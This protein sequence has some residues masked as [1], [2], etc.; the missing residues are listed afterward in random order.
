MLKNCSV[1]VAETTPCTCSS[2][3]SCETLNR[4]TRILGLIKLSKY[5][6]IRQI[7]VTSSYSIPYCSNSEYW[8]QKRTQSES[9]Y[10]IILDVHVSKAEHRIY[11]NDICYK[12]CSESKSTTNTTNSSYCLGDL[13]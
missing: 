8:T 12:K 3:L 13:T 2:D 11:H 1:C 10:S 7:Y 6:P 5:I 9:I 4:I